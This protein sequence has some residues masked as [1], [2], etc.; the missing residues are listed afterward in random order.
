MAKSLM[1]FKILSPRSKVIPSLH[2]SGIQEA[3]RSAE[4]AQESPKDSVDDLQQD[5]EPVK[6]KYRLG[7]L[8]VYPYRTS[9]NGDDS[10]AK[11]TRRS[12]IMQTPACLYYC[13]A[14]NMIPHLL[15]EVASTLKNSA[16][17]NSESD[18][19]VSGE[20]DELEAKKIR[21]DLN[22]HYIPKIH[23]TSI[24]HFINVP[25]YKELTSFSE[26]T[27]TEVLVFR[28]SFLLHRAYNIP[29]KDNVAFLQGSYLSILVIDNFLLNP[30][31]NMLLFLLDIIQA[32]MVGLLL[33]WSFQKMFANLHEL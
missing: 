9:L 21:L 5:S 33:I 26:F 29:K 1:N 7:C 25:G 16:Y 27:S 3:L 6:G 4:T 12:T 19:R 22:A 13:Q 18:T 23:H 30:V 17:Q 11:N 10:S 2:A 28:F 32:L 8:E 24:D 15:P 14:A 20:K 31:K